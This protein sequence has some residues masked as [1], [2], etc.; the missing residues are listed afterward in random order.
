MSNDETIDTVR[1][2]RCLV[3]GGRGFIGSHLV[4]AL[5]VCAIDHGP[6]PPTTRTARNVAASR[7]PLC[8]CLAAGILAISDFHGGAI[9]RA[10]RAMLTVDRACAAG[11]DLDVAAGSEVRARRE[12][13]ERIVI[14]PAL[15][16][17]LNEGL[18]G[19][20]SPPLQRL[21]R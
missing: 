2:K 11:K 12:A 5:L 9:E 19:D 18:E 17:L 3:L 7:S 1:P 16:D 21:G 4:D 20:G 10:M 6:T 13:G 15:C 8:S 14:A